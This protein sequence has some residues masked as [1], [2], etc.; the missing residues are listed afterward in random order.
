LITITGVKKSYGS[1]RAVNNVSLSVNAG[2]ALGLLGPNGAG[3]TTTLSMM[4]GLIRPDSGEVAIDGMDPRNPRARRLVG[5]APQSLALYDELTAEENLVFFAKI[6]GVAGTLLRERINWA[7][8]LSGLKER[9]SSPV[10]TFSGGMKRRLNLACAL[11]HDPKVVFLDEP[12]VGV[13][14]QSRNYIFETVE[15]LKSEGLAIVYTTHYMEEAERLCDIVAIMDEG[16]IKAMD[17]VPALIQK[18]GGDSVITADFL[19]L[20]EKQYP[21]TMFTGSMLRIQS[22]DPFA[23]IASLSNSGGTLKSLHIDQP[24]LEAVFLNLTGKKLRD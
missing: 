7:L 6:F 15:R 4:S 8:S 3:K 23:E 14:P 16:Q 19:V 11:V 17:T 5:L 12:T 1:I 20:P 21:S 10:G 9:R 22:K 18:F 24:D 13:D 2:E